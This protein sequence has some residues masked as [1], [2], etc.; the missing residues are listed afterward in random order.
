MSIHNL[1][2]YESTLEDLDNEIRVHW[3]LN[4]C[5][6]A[7]QLIEIYEHENNVCLVLDY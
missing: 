1:M 6:G 4:E 7:L 2:M 3:A 5:E